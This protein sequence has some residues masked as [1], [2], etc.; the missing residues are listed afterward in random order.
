MNTDL[1]CLDRIDNKTIINNKKIFEKIHRT[2]KDKYLSYDFDDEII[3]P[4]VINICLS[5]S[6]YSIDFIKYCNYLIKILN[7]GF[8]GKIESKYKNPKYSPKY[9]SELVGSEPNGKIIYDYI[10]YK[11]DTKIRFY[12]KSIEYFD[13][14]FEYD[15]LKNSTSTEELINNFY[16]NGFTTKS[17]NKNCLNINLIKFTCKTLGVSTFPWEKHI[18]KKSNYPMLV[19]IDYKTINPE[20][21]SNKFN[22]CRTLIHEV[23]HIFGLKHI[24]GCKPDSITSYKI[25]LGDTIYKNIFDTNTNTDKNSIIKLY[26][27]IPVQKKPTLI[28]PIEKNKFDIYKEVPVNF[29]C[30]MDY[31]P[32]EVLTHFT[33]SQILIMRNI[34]NIYK[35]KLIT[36]SKDYKNEFVKLYLPKDCVID[37]SSDKFLIKKLK[38]K[39]KIYEYKISYV[40]N[41]YVI[42]DKYKTIK[43]RKILEHNTINENIENNISTID[44]LKSIISII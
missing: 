4:V 28:N 30:F 38:D 42:L 20:I 6:D 41:Q 43:T 27:D 5:Y 15:F 32:D 24:F 21:S 17:E 35:P 19:F 2:N 29:A 8:S 18:L 31:S 13:K 22:K 11:F 36:K 39:N 16:S 40:E 23:G 14:N 1:K 26:P 10:N 7:D 25:I 12:L 33:Q 37:K 44:K 34:I 3:I 9:F